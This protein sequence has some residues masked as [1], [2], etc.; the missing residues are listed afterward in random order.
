MNN[1][2]MLAIIKQKLDKF[3]GEY[4]QIVDV[5]DKGTMN[6]EHLPE[7]EKMKIRMNAL[8]SRCKNSQFLLE[9]II[10]AFNAEDKGLNQITECKNAVSNLL[11]NIRNEL[12]KNELLEMIKCLEKIPSVMSEIDKKIS[13]LLIETDSDILH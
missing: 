6:T 10:T 5:F 8:E 13:S 11:S 1:K 9:N 4:K 12:N 7:E 2:E 3:A